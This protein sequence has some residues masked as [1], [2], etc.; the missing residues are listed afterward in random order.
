MEYVLREFPTTNTA[1]LRILAVALARDAI[2]G[3]EEIATK[4]LSGRKKPGLNGPLDQEKLEYIKAIVR[5]RVPRKS[6]VESEDVW[7][8]CRQNLSKS[9]QSIRNSFK[10]KRINFLAMTSKI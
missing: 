3:Q 10:K 7:A 6:P 1:S 9:C 8:L 2:I 4:S 5:I